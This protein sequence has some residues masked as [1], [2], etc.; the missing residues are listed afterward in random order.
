[1]CDFKLYLITGSPVF[2]VD[3]IDPRTVF[4]TNNEIGVEMPTGL[5]KN[6]SSDKNKQQYLQ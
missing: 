2:S 3:R 6:N 5:C 4:V 1:M